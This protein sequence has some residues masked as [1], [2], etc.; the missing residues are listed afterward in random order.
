MGKFELR[1]FL[2][3]HAWAHVNFAAGP[4]ER[5]K[6]GLGLFAGFFAIGLLASTFPVLYG[7]EWA[8]HRAALFWTLALVLG[9]GI[10]LPVL[11]RYVYIGVMAFTGLI[12]FLINTILLGF[13][14][15]VGFTIASWL[16]KATG[17][18]LLDR[19]NFGRKST[20]HEH[21]PSSGPN[22]YHHLS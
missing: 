4:D 9:L 8:W 16:L 6:T 15:F 21:K 10:L 18:D 5:R 2:I 7:K 19:K 11:G 12:A 14:F 20:W 17:K 13:I 1:P 22:S 3:E